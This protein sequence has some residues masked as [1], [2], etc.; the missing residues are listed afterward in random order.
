MTQAASDADSGASFREQ[1]GALDRVYWI[2]NLME[3]V[4]RLAYY[5]L[6]TVVPIYMVLSVAQGG[7]QFDHVQK[8]QIFAIWAGIQSFVPIFT[9]GY[10]DRYGY[11]LT[12]AAAIGIKVV[13]Y[14]VM[15]FAIPI[16]ALFVGDAA[17]GVPGHP[18]VYT[19]FLVGA[20]FLA[21]GTA[22]FK[23]GLQGIIAVRLSGKNASIGWALF[24]ALVN[25]G[26]FLGPLLASAMRLLAW[27]WVFVSCALIICV[28]YG[29]LLMFAEPDKG[30]VAE[31]RRSF[32]RVL[33]DS[34]IGIFEPRL[35][36]FL[37][38]FSGFW[39]MFY[40]L[41]DLLPNFITDWVDSSR[42]VTSVVAPLMGVMGLA[43]PAAWQGQL[44]AEQMV[45]VNAGLIVIFAFAVGY[46]TG[47]VRSMTAMFVGII[48]SAAA[49]AGLGMSQSG[50]WIIAM[51]AVFSLGE[52]SASPTKMRYIA[53]IAPPGRKGL[54]LGYVN[55]TVG[56][57]WTIGSLVSG[58][59]YQEGGDKVVL[60]RRYL[61]EHLGRDLTEIT[62]LPKDDVMG[63]LGSAIGA[64][65]RA[66]TDL[67]WTTYAPGWVWLW[68]AVVGL[69][70]M[71]GLIVFDQITRRAP[72]QEAAM[73][74]VLTMVVSAA[75]YGVGW[76]F[77]YGGS[78]VLQALRWAV[79]F[80]APMA[81]WL[82]LRKYAPKLVPA[83][84]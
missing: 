61:V 58:K 31:E 5:G 34:L 68:F 22:I 47:K 49:I 50:W 35:M 37:V 70:S 60:A 28:N 10:A 20:V 56:I 39:M 1:F 32:L 59:L 46:L 45:N 53:N 44:P 48:I 66:G 27:K 80:G 43:E 79:T 64:T 4:E 84:G 6:R 8:G 16:A 23:P 33:W 71:V 75:T 57:G 3:M 12:V 78:P 17:V 81:L 26:G 15:G 29:L 13:G 76:W 52:M 25:V 40:Q 36:A 2:A 11:K 83:V 63:A 38:V 62:N 73:L 9:G 69:I 30:V 72:R 14:L 51:I 77:A 74:I 7:P 82:G 55:A 54:Y 21:A 41:F 19:S 42:V 67:L 65:G 18:A 24:Y